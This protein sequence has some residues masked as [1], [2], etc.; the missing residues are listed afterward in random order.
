LVGPVEQTSDKYPELVFMPALVMYLNYLGTKVTVKNRPFTPVIFLGIISPY[1]K[2]YKSTSCEIAQEYF[3]VMNLATNHNQKL[4]S[5]N[6]QTVI[7]SPGSTEGLGLEM[8][9]M[10]ARNAVVFFDELSKFIQKARIENS[11]FTD[12]ML[13]FYESRRFS[14]SIKARK[15]SFT[16]DSNSY[17]F[18]WMWCTTDRKFPTLWSKLPGDSSGLN[19]RMFFLITPDQPKK[20]LF[21]AQLDQFSLEGLQKTKACI[22][23]ATARKEYEY[24][25]FSDVDRHFDGLDAREQTLTERFALYFAVDSG[26]DKIMFEDIEK[27]KALTVYARDTKAYLD[28]VEAETLDG[29]LA[30]VIV[31][32]VQRSGGKVPYRDLYRKLDGL[33]QGR[34]WMQVFKTLQDQHILAYRDGVRGGPDHKPAMVYLLKEGI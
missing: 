27:A 1:G 30:K 29:R 23:A 11:S 9:R 24:D 15:E 18:S 6:G 33:G 16:F 14:N 31:R 26:H 10:Q 34:L 21:H 28:P 5:A 2:F 20:A 4:T 7:I 3:R 12:D 25:E 17:C 13:S 8:Y 19:D 32:E 22:S